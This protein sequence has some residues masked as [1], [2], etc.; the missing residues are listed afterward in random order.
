MVRRMA[1]PTEKEKKTP[2]AMVGLRPNVFKRV[3]NKIWDVFQ[4]TK[5]PGYPVTEMPQFKQLQAEL[6]WSTIFE[7]NNAMVDAENMWDEG[8]RYGKN[9]AGTIRERVYDHYM[10]LCH[11]TDRVALDEE[12]EIVQRG[13]G[14]L[15]EEKIKINVG[16][17]DVEYKYRVPKEKTVCYRDSDKLEG[18]RYNVVFF[19]FEGESGVGYGGIEGYFG[20]PSDGGTGIIVQDINNMLNDIQSRLIAQHAHDPDKVKN[21]RAKIE[22]IKNQLYPF[23]ADLRSYLHDFE[24]QHFRYLNGFKGLLG[25]Y[26]ELLKAVRGKILTKDQVVYRHTYRVIKPRIYDV[27]GNPGKELRNFP[28]LTEEIEAGVIPGYD[29]NGYPLEVT[30]PVTEEEGGKYIYEDEDGNEH[31]YDPG[32]VLKDIFNGSAT[33]RRV[34]DLAF[35][36]Y[37]DIIDM[38]AWVYVNWDAYRDDLRDGRYHNKSDC[39][40]IM[41]KIMAHLKSPFLTNQNIS[42]INQGRNATVQIN[43]NGPQQGRPSSVSGPIR[44]S[45][46]NPAFDLETRW[47]G[48]KW[49]SKHL[50]RKYYYDTQDHMP[51]STKRT[52]TTRGAALNILATVIDKTKKWDEMNQILEAI[53]EK[54]YG[55]DI[56]PNLGPELVRWGKP[57]TKNPFKPI[58]GAG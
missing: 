20:V 38:S 3:L 23:L 56:G 40:T 41:E 58:S 19:G 15:K 4:Y 50:G 28:Q 45:H 21:I 48:K 34:T 13:T 9:N 42:D 7:L 55:Y 57:L 37:V 1:E 16:G 12:R 43:L 2:A 35:T 29:E 33:P 8:P 22:D 14:E 52:I 6:D 18:R 30:W 39:I 46:L 49:K 53:G 5:T 27:H 51:E 32:Y 17:N 31:R 25:E 36:D 54:I 11:Y 44:P 47:K 26:E 24:N 10:K